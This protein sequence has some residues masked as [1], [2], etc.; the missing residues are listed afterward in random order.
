MYP[1]EYRA[2]SL[3][4]TVEALWVGLFGGVVYY[5][6]EVLWKGTS[7]WSMAMCGAICFWFLYRLN[8]LYT[9]LPLPLRA[10]VGAL[11]ITGVELVAGCILNVGLGWELWSYH[12][13]PL[14]FLGQICLPFSVLWFLLCFPCALLSYLIRRVVFLADA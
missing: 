8:R 1:V 12:H 14:N 7:H 9:H 11:F 3:Q 4:N 2:S 13:L 5:G 10:L 6:I